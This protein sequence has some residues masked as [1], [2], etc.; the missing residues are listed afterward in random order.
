MTDL[1]EIARVWVHARN[2]DHD[3]QIIDLLF[4]DSPELGTP[5]H[6]MW[7]TARRYLVGSM[8]D[9]ML[10]EL[11][12]GM[13]ERKVIK[14][15]YR[16]TRVCVGLNENLL[17]MSHDKHEEM[18]PAYMRKQVEK[19]RLNIVARVHDEGERPRNQAARTAVQVA[20]FDMMEADP[21][22]YNQRFF[23]LARAKDAMGYE[24]ALLMELE[25][26]ELHEIT[27]HLIMTRVNAMRRRINP[28]KRHLPASPS[29]ATTN[30]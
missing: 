24:H 9:T 19:M 1:I 23:S 10:R 14:W 21:A 30:T 26:I 5:E 18:A 25:Q 16:P 15:E 3:E 20:H 22:T 2:K 8:T 4:K 29:I 13:V 12:D 27:W 7:I 11:F 17:A 28:A 6:E